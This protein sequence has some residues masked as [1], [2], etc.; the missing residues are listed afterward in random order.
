ME[1][2]VKRGDRSERI[3]GERTKPAQVRVAYPPR[4]GFS[5][6][7]GK[8]LGARCMGWNQ[9]LIEP[10]FAVGEQAEP[11]EI[12]QHGPDLRELPIDHDLHAGAR[13][14]QPRRRWSSDPAEGDRV[15][16]RIAPS[17]QAKSAGRPRPRAAAPTA[18]YGA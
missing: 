16:R 11:P 4:D 8:F 17:P 18:P 2:Q 13:A 15:I 3:A 14:V 9:G 5:V 7:V 6:D 1:H 12:D 10:A